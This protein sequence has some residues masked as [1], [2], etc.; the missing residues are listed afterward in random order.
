MSILDSVNELKNQQEGTAN[1]PSVND[2]P[3]IRALKEKMAQNKLRNEDKIR[4][5]KQQKQI[6]QN[7][8]DQYNNTPKVQTGTE[9]IENTMGNEQAVQAQNLGANAVGVGIAKESLSDDNNQGT[10]FNVDQVYMSSSTKFSENFMTGLGNMIGD[11]GDISQMVGAALQLNT[12]AEGNFLSR[13]LQNAGNEMTE[14]HKS[15]IPP[16][17]QDPELSLSTLLNPDFWLIHGAQFTPQLLEIVATMGAGGA[18]K[19]GATV[20]IEKGLGKYF[21]KEL[22]ETAAE[23]GALEI[24][25]GLAMQSGKEAVKTVGEA[26]AKRGLVATTVGTIGAEKGIIQEV[27]QGAKGLGHL[28]R[29]TGK[30][31]EMGQKVA[32]GAADVGAGVLT[33]M[34][35]SIA[36][37]GEAYN[38]YSKM[39]KEDGSDMFTKEELSQMASSTF[40]NNMQYMMMDI[41]SWSLT[42]GGAKGMVGDGLNKMRSTVSSAAQKKISG[43]LAAKTISPAIKTSLEFLNTKGVKFLNKGKGFSKF[44]TTSSMEGLEESIQEVHE[45][46]SKMKGIE[47]ATGS[48]V[49]YDG[50]GNPKDTNSFFDF[51]MSKEMEGTK[52]IAGALGAGAGGVFNIRSLVDKSAE[53]AH[54]MSRRADFFKKS[55][56]IGSEDHR[57]QQLHVEASIYE[58]VFQGKEHLIDSTLNDLE[59]RGIITEEKS[60]EYRQ[61]AN[62]AIDQ[63]EKTNLLNFK[64]KKAYFTAIQEESTGKRMLQHEED[65]HRLQRS[66]L[67]EQFGQNDPESEDAD[68][69]YV[70]AVKKLEDAF[71]FRKA[72]ADLNIKT[73]QQSRRNLLA[74]KP[75]LPV[76]TKAG[77]YNSEVFYYNALENP[78]KIDN[79]E[80]GEPSEGPRVFSDKDIEVQKAKEH[81]ESLVSKGNE[82]VSTAVDSVKK[83]FDKA[84]EFVTEKVNNVKSKFEQ[85]LGEANAIA[86][87]LEK[88][89]GI[90]DIE[91]NEEGDQETKILNDKTI[92]SA[93]YIKPSKKMEEFTDEELENRFDEAF[94][95]FN[96][97]ENETK[98]GEKD[99]GKLKAI[100]ELNQEMID[101]NAENNNRQSAK[102]SPFLEAQNNRFKDVRAAAPEGTF[103]GINNATDLEEKMRELR[104][105]SKGPEQKLAAKWLSEYKKNKKP[106]SDKSAGRLADIENQLM[107]LYP[108]RFQTDDDV[109]TQL[110]NLPENPLTK[111]LKKEYKE[112]LS[113]EKETPQSTPEDLESKEDDALAEYFKQKSKIEKPTPAKKTPT[114][115][116]EGQS[117]DE[118][119]D[120]FDDV[121]ESR[122]DDEKVKANR[123]ARKNAENKK[124][125]K[126][127]T[128]K[129]EQKKQSNPNPTAPDPVLLEDEKTKKETSNPKASRS[130]KVAE[131]TAKAIVGSRNL[132]ITFLKKAKAFGKRFLKYVDQNGNRSDLKYYMQGL[133]DAE[134]F[135]PQHLA[136]M[137]E[138]NNS[139][140]W[141]GAEKPNVY[142]V[143]SINK[144]SEGRIAESTKGLFVGMA[145][146]IVMKSSAWND[147]ETYHHEFL[148][149]NFAYMAN[150][151]EMQAY[152]KAAMASNPKLL[153]KI[154]RV[155]N[156]RLLLSVPRNVAEGW[157]AET[158]LQKMKEL[159][160]IIG[161]Q[162]KNELGLTDRKMNYV[163]TN[164][165]NAELAK[166]G[167]MD[168][169]V[170]QALES[171]SIKVRKGDLY[172]RTSA[173]EIDF[174]TDSDAGIVSQLPDEDQLEIMDEFFV[175][176]QQG[177]RSKKYNMFFEEK[178][179]QPTERVDFWTKFKER[180]QNTFKSKEAQE[181]AK[182]E[183]L[184]IPGMESITDMDSAIWETFKDKFGE[185]SLDL[186]VRERREEFEK[187]EYAEMHADIVAR[188]DNL[189]EDIAQRE[190]DMAA[191]AMKTGKESAENTFREV[192]NSM[193]LD[194]DA[195]ETIETI[196][197]SFYSDDKNQAIKSVNEKI[198]ATISHINKGLN[199]LWV[200]QLKANPGT[201]VPNI[202]FDSEI[203]MEELFER[204]TDSPNFPDFM[205]QIENSKVQE[206]GLLLN[207]LE[208]GTESNSALAV[209][210]AYY[211]MNSNSQKVPAVMIN[212]DTNGRIS[213]TDAQSSF[214]KTKRDSILKRVYEYGNRNTKGSTFPFAKFVTAMEEIRL[215][216]DSRITPEMIKNALGYFSD[217]SV[218]INRIIDRGFI[219]IKGQNF[220]ISSVLKKM[221]RDSVSGKFTLTKNDGYIEVNPNNPIPNSG[222]IKFDTY[223]VNPRTD[224]KIR[225]KFDPKT[226]RNQPIKGIAPLAVN[227]WYSLLTDAVLVTD[228]QFRNSGSVRDAN[229]NINNT[230]LQN[231]A[232]INLFRDM[233]NDIL[234]NMDSNNPMTEAKF[235][236]RYANLSRVAKGKGM[237]S[238][239]FLKHIFDVVSKTKLPFTPQQL[240]GTANQINFE[241]RVLNDETPA[242]DA[243]NQLIL[244]NDKKSA[245]SYLMDLGRF[246]SSSRQFLVSA[247]FTQNLT[248]LYGV[249]DT[250]AAQNAFRTFKNLSEDN[251]IDFENFQYDLNKLANEEVEY[252]NNIRKEMTPEIRES[253]AMLKVGHSNKIE[254]NE[255][256][257][258]TSGQIQAIKDY[259]INQTFNGLFAT[260]VM[261]PDLKFTKNTLIKRSSSG[262]TTFTPLGDHVQ[263]E[264]IYFNDGSNGDVDTDGTAYILQEDL[265]RIAN[266]AGK[267]RPIKGH[268]KMTH[269]GVEH[270]G[271]KGM[272]GS[273][274]LDKPLYVGLTEEVVKQNPKLR[275]LY[276]TMLARKAKWIDS[277]GKTGSN[278]YSD[279]TENHLLT[280]VSMSAEKTKNPIKATWAVNIDDLNTDDSVRIEEQQKA[281]DKIYYPGGKFKGF[282]GQNVGP[283][284]VMNHNKS[285]SVVSS[286]LIGAIT[287]GA[288]TIGDLST[289]EKAQSLIFESMEANVSELASVVATGNIHVLTDYIKDNN[290]LNQDKMDRLANLLLFSDNLNVATPQARDLVLNTVK[291]FI[292]S[293]SNKLKTNGT[294]A[295]VIPSFAYV[296]KIEINGKEFNV[297]ES[298]AKR[299]EDGS[300]V[301]FGASNSGLQ[302]YKVVRTN[303]DGKWVKTFEPG[304]IV[305]PKN[306]Q[307]NGVK[308]REYFPSFDGRSDEG[309]Q[310]YRKALASAKSQ[311]KTAKDVK[312]FNLEGAKAGEPAYGYYVTGDVVM[313]T[314]IPSHGVQSTGFF[315]V[316]DFEASGNSQTMVPKQFGLITGQDHDGDTL[317]I[318]AKGKKTEKWNEA[319]EILKDHWLTEE[320]QREVNQ[321]LSFVEKT[322]EAL[323]YASKKL[324]RLKQNSSYYDL[325][326]HSPAG[327]R[328]QFSNTKISQANIGKVMS[329]HRTYGILANYGVDFINPINIGDKYTF[330]GFRDGQNFGPNGEYESRTILS[331]N[332]ANLV[333]DDVSN[334]FST[335][336]GIN[337]NTLKYVMPLVNMGVELGDIALIM[338][339]KAM[340]SWNS[341]NEFNDNIY[342]DNSYLS[343][344]ILEK[345]NRIKIL[346]EKVATENVQ[347]KIDFDNID[348]AESSV[349]IVH[350]ISQLSS[351]QNDMSKMSAIIRGHNNIEENAFISDKQLSEFNDFLN[352]ET[353][354]RKGM[355]PNFLV[356]SDDLRNSPLLENY[357]RSAE[358]M[359]DASAT[360]DYVYSDKGK[361]VWKVAV[362]NNPRNINV[363]KQKVIHAAMEKH[364]I[365]QS[366]G[367]AG[368]N[369][370]SYIKTLI[371]PNSE[372]NRNNIFER[373]GKYM[374][375]PQDQNAEPGTSVLTKGQSS[376]LFKKAMRVNNFGKNEMKSI[377]F[378]SA[379]ANEDMDANAIKLAQAEFELMPKKLQIDLAMYDLVTNGFKGQNSLFPLFPKSLKNQIER[380]L[381]KVLLDPNTFEFGVNAHSEFLD[382]FLAQNAN[383]YLVETTNYISNVAGKPSINYPGISLNKKQLRSI[384]SSINDG[385]RVY[386][387][388]VSKSRPNADKSNPQVFKVEPFKKETIQEWN[389]IKNGK[390]VEGLLKTT[391]EQELS[392]AEVFLLRNAETRISFVPVDNSPVAPVITSSTRAPLIPFFDGFDVRES[393]D[394]NE[395]YFTN[396]Q[397]MNRTE[398]DKVMKYPKNFLEAQKDM[399]FKEYEAAYI[400]GAQKN[401][402]YSNER[403]TSLSDDELMELYQGNKSSDPKD[404]GIGY[405]NKYAFAKIIN[406]VTKEMANRAALEQIALIRKKNPDAQVD[407][408]SKGRDI[409]SIQSWFM[410]SNIP[411]DH[412]DLQAAVRKLKAEE[413]VFKHE[414]YQ[415]TKKIN[416]A[417]SALY[418]EKLGFDPYSGLIGK[419]KY[420]YHKLKNFLDQGNIMK[421]IYGNLVVHEQF[422]N[423]Q[424]EVSNN[425]RYHLPEV[426]DAKYKAGEISDAEYNFYKTTSSIAAELKPF[427]G[428]VDSREGYIPHTSVGLME[429]YSRKGLLGVMVNLRSL[430]ENLGD[431]EMKFKVMKDGKMQEVNM[432]Y[433]DIV[434]EYM[435]RYNAEGYEKTKSGGLAMELFKLKK[436]ATE[437]LSIGENEDGT[438]IRYSDITI[439][440]TIG[441]V[442][443]NEFTQT[444]GQMAGDMPSWDLNKA[445]SDY[446][447]GVLF[448]NGN[449]KFN[450]F[451]QMLP[452][453]DG[454]LARAH[455][456]N[457]PNTVKYVEKIWRQYFLKGVKQHHLKTPASMK[458]LGISSDDVVDFITKGSLFYWLGYKGLV[459]G[460]GAYAIGN[461]LMGKYNHVKD[462][463]GKAWRKGESR[464]WTGGKA[465]NVSKPLEGLKNSMRILKKTGF[466][467]INVY[468]DAPL[469]KS[470]S[471]GSFLGDVALMPMTWGEN[472]I[473]GVQFLGELTDTEYKSLVEDENYIIPPSRMTEIE[474]SITLSQGKGYQPTD[475]RM[476]QM[477]SY[478]RMM[479]QFNRWIPTVYYNL[480]GKKDYDING[481]VYSGSYI[482]AK[483]ALAYTQFGKLISRFTTGEV[484][485]KSYA[486]YYEKLT[487]PEQDRLDSALR[488]FGLMALA[489]A[490]MAIGIGAG[491]KVLQDANVFA[492]IDRLK[493]KITPAA[494]GMVRNITGV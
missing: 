112:L 103:D 392:D 243:I 122:S 410:A 335:K 226:K 62:E 465:F 22:A 84:K 29:D 207:A 260:E 205:M 118:L 461:V 395:N 462:R 405:Q 297:T 222:Q 450:G 381:N 446:T 480:F 77:I 258:F 359:R 411:S 368:D 408:K 438:P 386:F 475:Q 474:S 309:S 470:S 38:T 448:N 289:M 305:V 419:A 282:S 401:A 256:A 146:T 153:E 158:T 25:K 132:L 186:E 12:L 9:Y 102:S 140:L 239:L 114:N 416:D 31:S 164:K 356:V 45:E 248:D 147:D 435:A 197:D 308:A 358:L 23:K 76:E 82:L 271:P 174:K 49:H 90:N 428:S 221:A 466:M 111:K 236:N 351:I 264:I 494:V 365:A 420:V 266:T 433:N 14:E 143:H 176:T 458:A 134:V 292:M 206:V 35:T 67:D 424:G 487:K 211:I 306:L 288:G 299:S 92:K 249:K 363:E 227:P 329:F 127:F 476:I 169:L 325:Y 320:M 157:D 139:G 489:S 220:K 154:K 166:R 217:K 333:V 262:S 228:S 377:R 393:R 430:D 252:W 291:Q 181:E 457:H 373:I 37:A 232:T 471:F 193:V 212:A 162:I 182:I 28:I 442:F 201:Y 124:A 283:Q 100:T 98:T 429:S 352:N 210:K 50:P 163:Q 346:G 294:Q 119:D 454:I 2:S 180:V 27:K 101:L 126:N 477:Y 293:N 79:Q 452:L 81:L 327:R 178:A 115:S 198:K 94:S 279:G 60:E 274:Q 432:K 286:Q 173:G 200:Q 190:I 105:R 6:N 30:I 125:L 491:E 383:D 334:G 55:L 85:K 473:Q 235:I 459:V 237:Y 310:A 187:E 4:A 65:T 66:E 63:R 265:D 64:G 427:S 156:D 276:N 340:A 137:D 17:L 387:K 13:A 53:D 423:D 57:N 58:Q 444:R 413:K 257:Q 117:Q 44:A 121:R 406:R 326:L 339:S 370:K 344:N 135:G 313:G 338:N 202:E 167:G 188:I 394:M 319:F 404:R 384:E 357:K 245:K 54:Q 168:E 160:M 155:Y 318:N 1:L 456:N 95:E 277:S 230:Q 172:A 128:Q 375:E 231:N 192:N 488:G 332:I 389:E 272:A 229:G 138:I 41:A 468:D 455:E 72:S 150:T 39:K 59:A 151:P 418:L 214:H 15:F 348:S 314:R 130:E 451:R 189:N 250:P 304:E 142:F 131:N 18:I 149:Y 337:H 463:G 295:R 69:D 483:D 75:G 36:N 213:V 360:M 285:E 391:A 194:P 443:V 472:W 414:K 88:E 422:T 425:M 152:L 447:H 86:D 68:P 216:P 317:Y 238:N 341:M 145:N 161:Q 184:D 247:P 481:E 242:E 185:G 290:L 204:A 109:A 191:L 61:A 412:P 263:H 434:A 171:D 439:G 255:D 374:S 330:K 436:K 73:A 312:P 467:E 407:L 175:A 56:K 287:T 378:N 148:H 48:L 96:R 449:G 32:S 47:E 426:M 343:S 78:E 253:I 93:D 307:K 342:T 302:D 372:T 349:G 369:V 315:E 233:S 321:P 254:P 10:E 108:N 464:F 484:S 223:G 7:M 251:D 345:A 116:A 70:A 366:L 281:M 402:E 33:N 273:S 34:R 246:S 280:A 3:R 298:V 284:I 46:W 353:R 382:N 379:I 177:A 390:K 301:N 196:G 208:R 278:D 486:E 396:E 219:T 400:F 331:A 24:G 71:A 364:T 209:M 43:A 269:V 409:S 40:S 165:Y 267:Y 316:V 51:Y 347:G 270:D 441:D 225:Y 303:V 199:K 431:V 129:K 11:Y 8:K 403:L 179:L 453:F 376:I 215:T 136:T 241:G 141:N 19:K 445:F 203:L 234:T 89:N 195:E 123:K 83:G 478:G 362:T 91:T 26:A 275:G 492:D 159:E 490:G 397:E 224:N 97:L 20:G 328:S 110:D 479:M 259:T 144:L 371:E 5:I 324:P 87:A 398:F 104:Q 268:I 52:T 322:K 183:A 133:S 380:S 16:E 440:S 367:L 99:L 460:Q 485:P 323:E 296:K 218:D 74:G 482:A 261:F 469:H 311:G 417:T 355:E 106:V 107:S 21:A 120:F 336:L 399:L 388:N 421:Q 170:L 361:K 240:Y 437:L 385:S 350:L 80:D 42:F 354:T 415:Y 300:L 493:L 244:F 113:Y